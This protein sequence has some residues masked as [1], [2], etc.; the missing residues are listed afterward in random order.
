MP[1]GFFKRMRTRRL[2]AF[3]SDQKGLA[4]VEFAYVAPIL[5]VLGMGGAELTNYALTQMRISQLAI[6]LADN[7]SRARQFVSGAALDFANTMF[8]R[9]FKGLNCNP[10]A[11]TSRPMDASCCRALSE[12]SPAAS[13]FTG[14]AAL[15]RRPH[16]EPQYGRQG[17]GAVGNTYPGMGPSSNRVTAEQ[18]F[19][20]MYVEVAYEYEPLVFT[21]IVPSQTIR[22]NAAMFV[23]DDRDLTGDLL[24]DP[25]YGNV[26]NPS[27]AVPDADIDLCA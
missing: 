23:R 14:N 9:F 1:V 7:A 2:S 22:K 4:L 11:S 17:T 5:L 6:S 3:R 10:V 27:P 20:V 16:Y 15:E 21:T 13:G 19:A 24:R 25:R 26:F 8:A 12:I 18:N